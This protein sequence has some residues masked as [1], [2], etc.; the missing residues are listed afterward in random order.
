MNLKAQAGKLREALGPIPHRPPPRESGKRLGTIPRGEDSEIRVTWD[1]W[2]RRPFLSIRLWNRGSDG[3]LYPDKAR[4]IAIRVR[5]LPA[6]A[7]AISLALDEA[8][9]VQ[10]AG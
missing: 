7:E 2:E 8:E 1:V 6:F 4:G 10:D 9:Q 3:N 5:E